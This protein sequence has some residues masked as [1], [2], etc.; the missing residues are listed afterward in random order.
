MR[1]A[2][3]RGQIARATGAAAEKGVSGVGNASDCDGQQ[4][5]GPCGNT[6]GEGNRRWAEARRQWKGQGRRELD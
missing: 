6:R 5:G 4:G 1:S 2:Q 3:V